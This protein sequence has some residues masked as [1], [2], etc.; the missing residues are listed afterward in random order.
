VAVAVDA[1]VV[2]DDVLD[3]E[4]LLQDGAV[5]HLALHRQ[6][7]LEALAVRLGPGVMLCVDDDDDDELKMMS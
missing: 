3:H 4:R 1:H 5:E 2:L 7:D 6:L